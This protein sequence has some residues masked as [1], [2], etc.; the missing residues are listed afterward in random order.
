MRLNF[1][2]VCLS[3]LLAV[4]VQTSELRA[5]HRN[6]SE[7][8]GQMFLNMPVLPK[9]RSRDQNENTGQQAGRWEMANLRFVNL[10]DPLQSWLSSYTVSDHWAGF[11]GV[12]LNFFYGPHM[13]SMAPV[14]GSPSGGRGNQRQRLLLISLCYFFFFILKEKL[15][16]EKLEFLYWSIPSSEEGCQE[17]E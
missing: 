13:E 17:N 8:H 7:Q 2:R 12:P 14:T 6:I 9:S 11:C 4:I 3:T 16:L 1:P 10:W 15:F 5:S